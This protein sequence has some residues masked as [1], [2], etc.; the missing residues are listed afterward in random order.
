M[1]WTLWVFFGGMILLMFLQY[2]F[3]P[4]AMW[5]WPEKWNRKKE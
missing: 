1:S 2:L 5:I 4:R 3:G